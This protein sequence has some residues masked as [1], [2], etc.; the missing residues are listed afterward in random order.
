MKRVGSAKNVITYESPTPDKRKFRVLVERDFSGSKSVAAGQLQLSPGS[1]QPGAEAHPDTE[2][3]Y[4]CAHGQG[5]LTLDGEEYPLEE[6]T[7]AYVGPGARHQVFN[8]GDEDLLM[9][10]FE[11]PPSCEVGGYKP[12]TLGWKQIPPVE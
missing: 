12:M 4:Y 11:S 9:I 6:G 5:K 10:W 2:E 8:T 7:M 3:I 1:A